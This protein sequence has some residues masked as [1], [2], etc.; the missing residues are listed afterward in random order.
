VAK[1]QRSDRRIRKKRDSGFRIL[2]SGKKSRQP[3]DP[4]CRLKTVD[5]RLRDAATAA[6]RMESLRAEPREEWQSSVKI[7]VRDFGFRIRKR[8]KSQIATGSALAM[9]FGLLYLSL[10]PNP[11]ACG[12]GATAQRQES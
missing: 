6:D 8:G 10:D 4:C 1:W 5:C 11:A 2:A 9:T 3:T 12:C 7:Q